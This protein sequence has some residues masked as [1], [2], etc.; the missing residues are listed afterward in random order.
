MQG[1]MLLKGFTLIEIM[2]V[3]AIVAILAAIAYPSYQDSVRKSR[4][5]DAKAV[6]LQAG[7]W[8]ERFYTVNNRYD[9][10]QA[11]TAVA[12]TFA[13]TGLT[14]SPIDGATKYY[15]ITLT[16][17]TATAFILN[18]APIS[19]KGQEYDKCGGMTGVTLTLNQQTQKGVS[20]TTNPTIIGECW[21]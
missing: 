16:N 9:Q 8:M 17:V 21:R 18:A 19:G 7:Q 12:T 15:T 1:K 6:V 13:T 20:G 3:V 2:I 14:Q 4:R 10:D 11:G 5:A